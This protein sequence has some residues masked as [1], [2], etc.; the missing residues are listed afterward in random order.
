MINRVP[1]IAP[2]HQQLADDLRR[3]IA[4]GALGVGDPVPSEAQLCSAFGIS[5]GT[6]RQALAALRAEG[7]IGGGRGKPPVVRSRSIA[8]PFA[9]FIS[10]SAWAAQLGRVPGQRTLEIARRPAGPEA[11]DGL[12][13]D[14][15]EPVVELLRLRLLDGEPTMLER[16][17]YVEAVGRLL[18]DFD[19]DQGSTFAYLSGR[20]VDLGVARHVF[21]AVAADAVDSELLAVAAGAPLLRERRRTT[22][23]AGAPIE[24]GDDRYRPDLVTF[25]VENA[26]QQA[27][28]AL[29]RVEAA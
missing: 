9:T 27:R 18:F 13:L 25:T 26:D 17:T 19:P 23:Q 15:G 5:R 20:G 21:D 16:T 24:W 8:Q 6:V 2:L 4:T 3:R 14:P 12:G 10:F 28:P 1:P 11:A 29:A 22:T 7:V